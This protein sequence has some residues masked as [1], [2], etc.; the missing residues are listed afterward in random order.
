M[1]PAPLQGLAGRRTL[2]TGGASGIG[3]AI[4]SHLRTCGSEVVVVDRQPTPD[5]LQVDLG[6]PIA[7]GHLV[8]DLHTRSWHTLV[9][10][11]GVSLPSR[12]DGMDWT[13]YHHTLAVNLHAAVYLMA[14]LGPHLTVPGRIVNVSSVHARFGEPLSTAYDVSKAGLEAA[15]RSAAL[16]LADAGVLVNCV[17]PGFVATPMSLVDGVDELTTDE[18][19]QTYVDG[20][21][22]PLRRAAQPDEVASLVSWLASELNTYVTG[23]SVMIDGGLSIRF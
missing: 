2:V 16:E 7:L 12:L 4:A 20:A 13:S 10:C 15:T 3:A 17:S 22:I 19:R 8:E 1:T 23:Q 18:F 11:A 6:D 9:N 21:R 14:E 5:G